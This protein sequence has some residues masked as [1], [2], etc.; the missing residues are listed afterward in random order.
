MIV[1]SKMLKKAA[2]A[3]AG[4]KKTKKTRRQYSSTEP[5]DQSYSKAISLY[6]G[7]MTAPVATTRSVTTVK[8]RMR[9]GASGDLTVHHRE[10]VRDVAGSIAFATVSYP[11]NP[12]QVTLFP[13][14]SSIAARYESYR[15]NSL[16]F[17]LNTTAPTSATGTVVLAIDYDALDVAPASKT[18]I[19]SYRSAVRG[20]PWQDTA[21]SAMPEDIHRATSLYTR[22]TT[23][24]PAAA[25]LKTYDVG[26][27]FVATQGQ[28]AATVIAELYVEYD[29]T[30][31]TPQL[32]SGFGSGLRSVGTAGLA[33]NVFFGTNAS[34]DADSTIAATI[35]GTGDVLTFSQDFSGL[36]I[37]SA[38]GTVLSAL[39]PGGSAPTN[40]VSLSAGTNNTTMVGVWKV[41][42][43]VG[44]TL[45]P[46]ITETTF[47][48]SQIIL[49]S[50]PPTIL[51]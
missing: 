5:Q 40:L 30:L 2:K 13:W 16:R 8:P 25:D 10:F 35:V 9:S 50:L 26:N 21:L 45:V 4:P 12:G 20:A 14:L 24:V 48:S 18:Q 39:A 51:S 43:I 15:F 17:A 29:V 1:T 27:L 44:Q 11:I 37:L 28:G 42:A 22:T 33:A 49:A 31:L 36:L 3:A 38:V 6:G 34:I 47:T 41:V 46:T 7:R 19:M 23:A 32:D